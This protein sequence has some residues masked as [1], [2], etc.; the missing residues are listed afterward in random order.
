MDHG[1]GFF[2]RRG[3]RQALDKFQ[4]PLV[5]RTAGFPAHSGKIELGIDERAVEIK[6]DALHGLEGQDSS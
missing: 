3:S 6:N 4:Q 1:Q 5:L 2:L